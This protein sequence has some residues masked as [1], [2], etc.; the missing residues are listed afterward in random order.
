MEILENFSPIQ[1][2]TMK[3][4]SALKRVDLE[5]KSNLGEGKI[6]RLY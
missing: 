1:S 4:K 6:S 5:Q 3:K 2:S